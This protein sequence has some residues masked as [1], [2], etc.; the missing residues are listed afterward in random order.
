[1]QSRGSFDMRWRYK[2]FINAARH[3]TKQIAQP[4]SKSFVSNKKIDRRNC[5]HFVKRNAKKVFKIEFRPVE[6]TSCYLK[7]GCRI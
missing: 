2:D 5:P 4:Q 1:M 7:S 3:A 6:L